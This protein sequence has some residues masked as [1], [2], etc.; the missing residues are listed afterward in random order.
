MAGVF[1][2]SLALAP[3]A[4]FIPSP[5]KLATSALSNVVTTV[6]AAPVSVISTFESPAK[7]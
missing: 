7:I 3:V 5:V 4:S 1:E 2:I 6:A